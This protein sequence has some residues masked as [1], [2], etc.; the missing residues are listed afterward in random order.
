MGER[1]MR[2]LG[3]QWTDDLLLR[4]LLRPLLRDRERERPRALA[5]TEPKSWPMMLIWLAK[6]PGPD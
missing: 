5:A 2:S 1:G 4:S 6:C 3:K